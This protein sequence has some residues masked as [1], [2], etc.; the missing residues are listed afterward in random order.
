VKTT[1]SLN[2]TLPRPAE[3]TVQGFHSASTVSALYRSTEGKCPTSSTLPP[4]VGHV[5]MPHSCNSNCHALVFWSGLTSVPLSIRLQ[6]HGISTRTTTTLLIVSEPM[7]VPSCFSCNTSQTFIWD[8]TPCSP[9][10]AERQEVRL[11]ISHYEAGCKGRTLYVLPK[12]HC[13]S[14]RL[15]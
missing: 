15:H 14:T 4:V 7:Y 2:R 3:P 12:C 13:I 1:K 10:Q 11:E 5:L 9:V 6:I 8:M